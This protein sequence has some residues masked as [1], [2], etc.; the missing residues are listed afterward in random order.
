MRPLQNNFSHSSRRNATAASANERSVTILELAH[1]NSRVSGVIVSIHPP[2]SLLSGTTLALD[3]II[4]FEHDRIFVV[5][6]GIH[7]SYH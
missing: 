4:C 1:L 5:V 3:S 6:K 2:K 7:P